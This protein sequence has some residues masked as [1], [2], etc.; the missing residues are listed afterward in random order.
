MAVAVDK[1]GRGNKAD[2][3]EGAEMKIIFMVNMHTMDAICS[4]KE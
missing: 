2:G 3:R 1:D 4:N